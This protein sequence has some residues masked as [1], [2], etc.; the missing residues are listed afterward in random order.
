MILAHL[1]DIHFGRENQSALDAAREVILA[2]GAEAVVV[3]GDLTQR[4]KR[5]E[6][7]ASREYLRSFDLPVLCVPGN[8][9]TPLLHVG[10]R[11]TNAFGRYNSFMSEFPDEMEAERILIRGL[12]TSRGWQ[13]RSNWAEGSVSLRRLDHIIGVGATEDS[14]LI[15]AVVC[16]HPFRQPSKAR[17]RTATRRGAEASRRLAASGVSLL[18]TGHVHTPHAEVIEEEEGRYLAITAGTLSTRLRAEQPSF[19][20]ITLGTDQLALSVLSFSDG[21]F[22]QSAEGK[23]S[24]KDLEP[25]ATPR[26]VTVQHQEGAD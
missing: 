18:L 4:G 5:S 11:A 25:V 8:H 24:L 22:T 7:I 3:A 21:S 9:D 14:P 1:A 12:N 13:A 10:A 26:V 16:H 6:F 23:W 19:N 17:L 20:L 15:R 2:S